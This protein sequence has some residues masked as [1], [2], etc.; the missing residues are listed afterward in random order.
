MSRKIWLPMVLAAVLIVVVAG[1][2]FAQSATPGLGQAAPNPAQQA[3]NGTAPQPHAE[4]LDWVCPS[5]SWV[6]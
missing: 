6:E 2:V 5:A 1:A 4:A 3:P